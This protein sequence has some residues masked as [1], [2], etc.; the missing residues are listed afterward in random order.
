MMC[1]VRHHVQI[2][3]CSTIHEV[4]KAIAV[5]HISLCWLIHS[6]AIGIHIGGADTGAPPEDQICIGRV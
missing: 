1:N 4:N 6:D 5:Q 2:P 3:T